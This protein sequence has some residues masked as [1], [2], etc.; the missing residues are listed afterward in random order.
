MPPRLLASVRLFASSR[1]RGSYSLTS[2]A[3][4]ATMS[5]K[6]A[7]ATDFKSFGSDLD[8]SCSPRTYLPRPAPARGE[9][10]TMRPVLSMS[11]AAMPRRGRGGLSRSS[12]SPSETWPVYG[13]RRFSPCTRCESLTPPGTTRASSIVK[14]ATRSRS[15]S[16]YATRSSSRNPSS[17]HSYQGTLR[18]FQP[19]CA[20]NR[21]RSLSE[22]SRSLR[23]FAQKCDGPSTSIATFRPRSAMSIENKLSCV[24]YSISCGIPIR[25]NAPLT[26]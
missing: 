4:S 1:F 6:I 7:S 8:P 20:R 19:L 11:N 25:V 14:P 23:M 21:S 10:F 15:D 24:R 17:F 16:R 13:C 22:P 18:T 2:N 12:S 5:S 9:F 3:E 26:S